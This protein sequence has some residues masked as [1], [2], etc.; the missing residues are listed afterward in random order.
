MRGQNVCIEFY[1]KIIGTLFLTSACLHFY[2]PLDPSN[3]YWYGKELPPK[4]YVSCFYSYSAYFFML[5]YYCNYMSLNC[6]HIRLH[7]ISL[8]LLSF[9]I[10]P[11][12]LC[13]FIL[14]NSFYFLLNWYSFLNDYLNYER[15]F[16]H[17]KNEAYSM[18]TNTSC[19]NLVPHYNAR[20]Q[21]CSLKVLVN[22]VRKPVPGLFDFFSIFCLNTLLIKLKFLNDWCL[23]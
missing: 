11:L 19:P 21:G 10:L 8:W 4:V 17:T 23:L 18:K 9:F 15:E 14:V 1:G 5:C 6:F 20:W 2:L 12:L 3:L 7:C 13:C 22:K 16:N